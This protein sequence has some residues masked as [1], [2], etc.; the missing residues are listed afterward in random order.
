ME[1]VRLYLQ[2]VT[3]QGRDCDHPKADMCLHPTVFCF[4]KRGQGIRILLS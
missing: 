2:G 4:C 3:L 1:H